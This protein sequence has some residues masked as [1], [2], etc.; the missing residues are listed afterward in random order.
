MKKKVIFTV[1]AVVLFLAILF[2]PIPQS[3]YD[4]GGTRGYTALT[5]KIVDWNRMSVDSIYDETKVYWFPDNFKSVDELWEE[6]EAENMVHRMVAEVL[7]L[8]NSVLVKPVDGEEELLS[9]DKIY[10][11]PAITL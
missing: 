4:D 11:N 3:P 7:E 2:A 8:G 9:S 1:V 6:Y 5:Y 10:I